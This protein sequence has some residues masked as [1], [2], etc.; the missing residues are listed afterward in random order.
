[1]ADKIQIRRDTAAAWTAANPTL[2]QGEMALET[3]TG[4]VKVGDGVLAWTSLGYITD[5][6]A[7]PTTV[8]AFIALGNYDG[9]HYSMYLSTAMSYNGENWSGINNYQGTFPWTQAMW[10]AEANLND[11]SVTHVAA[12]AGKVV[13]VYNTNNTYQYSSFLMTASHPDQ[14]PTIIPETTY[15][16]SES[17]TWWYRWHNVFY[18]GGYFVAVGSV[19]DPG[20]SYFLPAFLYSTDGETW[21]EGDIDTEYVVLGLWATGTNAPGSTGIRITDVAYNGSGWFFVLS[22]EYDGGGGPT[23]PANNL[24]GFYI[25]SL[26]GTLQQS[27]YS[28][29][30]P[31]DTPYLWFDAVRYVT[32]N[33]KTWLASMGSA[34]DVYLNANLNPLEGMWTERNYYDEANDNILSLSGDVFNS[35]APVAIEALDGGLIGDDYVLAISNSIGQVHISTDQGRTWTMSVPDPFKSVVATMAAN[36]ESQIYITLTDDASRRYFYADNQ[37]GKGAVTITGA[38]GETGLNDNWVLGD[39]DGGISGFYLYQP[40]GITNVTTTDLPGTYTNNSAT[41]TSDTFGASS[42]ESESLIYADGALYFGTWQS[43]IHRWDGTNWNEVADMQQNIVSGWAP[44]AFCYGEITKNP[45]ETSNI[46][47]G[48]LNRSVTLGNTSFVDYNGSGP[49]YLGVIQTSNENNFDFTNDTYYGNSYN[50]IF[51]TTIRLGWDHMNRNI[52]LNAASDPTTFY[53][54]PHELIPLP[55]GYT[56]TFTVTGTGFNVFV[57]PDN[58]VNWDLYRIPDGI[59]STVSGGVLSGAAYFVTDSPGVHTLR[60]VG[61]YIWSFEGPG[62]AFN[63]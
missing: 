48:R 15:K 37:P 31:S 35:N 43:R 25:T 18:Q 55:I 17:S 23:D 11:W 57:D 56:V 62:A 51:D 53:I 19:W 63:L 40:D 50:L 6:A 52:L 7:D 14:T 13:Y 39:Y 38:T 8:D 42:W 9:N 32:W 29:I 33:G 49:Q 59:V 60:K 21:T 20:N 10:N 45:T 36:G 47:D 12:G 27:N 1:M 46:H 61:E 26:N 58:L 34:W 2:S 41:L 16:Q 54:P 5:A 24:G 28:A 4:K 3:D 44:Y 30:W 22:Y